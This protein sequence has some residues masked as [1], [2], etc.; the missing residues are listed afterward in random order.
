MRPKK[1]NH[2]P[3]PPGVIIGATLT[4]VLAFP[5]FLVVL[6]ALVIACGSSTPDVSPTSKVSL[7]GQTPLELLKRSNELMQTVGT[8]RAQLEMD[9]KIM[10]ESVSIYMD[11]EL[12]DRERMHN[13]LPIDTPD[14]R[15]KIEQ[16]ITDRYAYTR[17]PSEGIG[18][19]RMDLE[20]VAQ[21]AGL[22]S[23]LFSDPAS[24]GNSIFPSENIPWELY[25]VESTGR[26]QTNG[27]ET[28]HLKV[29]L[30]FQ[31]LWEQ[32][33]AEQKEAM[34]AC[35]SIRLNWDCNEP[36]FWKH[37]STRALICG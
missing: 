12:G 34:G 22:P 37:W 13:N 3:S 14:G 36:I 15:V 18:W 29:D 10:G 28:E 19:I 31:E 32:L 17:L 4:R 1:A 30:D 33:D 27:V 6:V 23:E 26:E 8:F 21:S 2:M 24:F 35:C 9:G 7:L 5:L 11:M 25:S 20:A 16:V